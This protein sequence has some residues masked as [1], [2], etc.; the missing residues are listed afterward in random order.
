MYGA[1]EGAVFRVA[2]QRYRNS[3]GVAILI[4]PDLN[5][6]IVGEAEGRKG[7]LLCNSF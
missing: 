7:T 5:V 3:R 1:G 6:D 2:D 4:D